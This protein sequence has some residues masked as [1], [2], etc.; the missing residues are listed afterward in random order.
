MDM[1]RLMLESNDMSEFK[2]DQQ[3]YMLAS[4]RI[5]QPVTIKAILFGM[6][7]VGFECSGDIWIPESRLYAS[8]E[9]AE[10]NLPEY[11]PAYPNVR[12]Y[13]YKMD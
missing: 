3:V 10:A 4:N 11:Q 6:C 7:R 12:T 1:E 13:I 5:V 8:K 9:E 2:T